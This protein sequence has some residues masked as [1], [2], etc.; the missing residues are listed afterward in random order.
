MM[1]GV[2]SEL[3]DFVLAHRRCTGPRRGDAS[4]LPRRVSRSDA[5]CLPND[6]IPSHPHRLFARLGLIGRLPLHRRLER[7]VAVSGVGHSRD[8]ACLPVR[9]LPDVTAT[10]LIRTLM[11][12]TAPTS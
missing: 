4:L 8:S 10:G 9:S 1:A 3:S 5:A 7:S 11:Y 6:G 2:Y 12:L